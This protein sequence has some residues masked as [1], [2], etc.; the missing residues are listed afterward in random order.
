MRFLFSLLFLLLDIVVIFAQIPSV[1]DQP[2]ILII[3][4][5][6]MKDWV[7]YLGG[8]E[9]KVFT[10]NIDK[11]AKEGV[12]FTNAH[13]AASVCCPSRYAMML[14][15]RPSTTGLYNNGQWYKPELPNE[16]PMSQYFKQNGYYAAGAGK[17][18]HHTPGNNPP[19]NWDDF[20][21]QVF[22][23]TW[24]F[25][26]WN[27]QKYFL[28][29]GYRGEIEKF[30]PWKPLNGIYPIRSELDWGPIPNKEEK[31]YGDQK[32]VDYAQGFLANMYAKPFFLALGIYRPH[33]P[34]HVPQKY[35]DLYPLED[36]IMP[37]IKE[38]D[39]SDVPKIG[40][41]L[42]LKR[43]IDFIQI[44]EEKL[45]KKAIQAYLA[46]ISYADYLVGEIINELKQSIYNKNTVVVLWSDHGWHL[47][48]KNHWHKQTLW[49]EC[50]KIPFII[51]APNAS[52]NGQLCD[53]PVDMVNVFPTLAALA[54]L[55][56]KKDIDGYDMT[57]LLEDPKSSWGYPAITEI[58]IG[59]V[60]VRSDKW[61]YILYN[62]GTEELYNSQSDPNEWTNLA[63]NV[64]Y[65]AVI[66]KH[67]KWVPKS[68]ADPVA[69]K[70]K[71]YFDPY[72]YSW[73]NRTTG[74]F[75]QGK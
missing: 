31:D 58:G 39:L 53:K 72:E 69:G 18:F 67:R 36:I 70:E 68:F 46:S 1:K 12:G 64:K 62:D 34:W 24:N 38:N 75:I 52:G 21:D 71:Y 13:T 65:M 7:G 26:E 15:K 16:I 4:V 57:S 41:E 54:N 10:P 60:S 66:S 42:A 33:L 17:V 40:V 19:C 29:Y 8:Y 74:E 51:R 56:A 44:K 27:P 48:T 35:Y 6:D 43:E 59:N 32:V 2:N 37:E 23:D 14:G 73:L 50:T 61:R 47:G 63:S 9:G 5:D 22:D 28:T 45:W 49:E 20:Q 30:P 25:A 11:L 55:P 3:S